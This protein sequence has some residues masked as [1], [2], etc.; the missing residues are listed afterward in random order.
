L[1]YSGSPS[2]LGKRPPI[3]GVDLLSGVLANEAGYWPT[4]NSNMRPRT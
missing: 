3:T 1:R 4:A 2:R